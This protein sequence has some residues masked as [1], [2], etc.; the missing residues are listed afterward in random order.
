MSRMPGMLD[1]NLGQSKHSR[2]VAKKRDARMLGHARHPRSIRRES[3][4]SLAPENVYLVLP[5][6]NQV[7]IGKGSH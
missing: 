2:V 7:K 1:E 5:R 4:A 6:A 3:R